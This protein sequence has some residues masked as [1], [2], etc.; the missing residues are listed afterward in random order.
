MEAELDDELGYSQNGYSCKLHR[1]SFGNVEVSISIDRKGEFEHR[2]L[3]KN[4]TTIRQIS[5]KRFSQCM[6]HTRI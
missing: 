5:K 6:L 2:K 3:K 4:Q 1:T